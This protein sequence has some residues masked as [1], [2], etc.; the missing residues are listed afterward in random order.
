MA[1]ALGTHEV[2]WWQWSTVDTTAQLDNLPVDCEIRD[3]A[4]VLC[5]AV[6]IGVAPSSGWVRVDI[7]ADYIP[8]LPARLL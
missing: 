8:T 3:S 7:G 4:G 5:R 2:R 6:G 1:I